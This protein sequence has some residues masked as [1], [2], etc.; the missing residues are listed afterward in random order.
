[1]R[2]QESAPW[3]LVAFGV[4]L[5]L[6]TMAAIGWFGQFW[7]TV[8]IEPSSP[9]DPFDPYSTTFYIKN[10]NLLPMQNTETACVASVYE[11][12]ELRFI[13]TPNGLSGFREAIPW[14]Q[15]GERY[16]FR[17]YQNYTPAGDP[18]EYLG[19]EVFSRQLVQA[20]TQIQVTYKIRFVPFLRF[21]QRRRFVAAAD[22]NGSF[23]WQQ[24]PLSEYHGWPNGRS[25]QYSTDVIVQNLTNKDLV[26][27]KIR[28]LK[29]FPPGKMPDD[30]SGDHSCGTWNPWERKSVLTRINAALGHYRLRYG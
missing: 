26:N 18:V 14:L 4:A 20:E 12:K 8:S 30:P 17:C 29:M 15:R 16:P 7:P 11:T 24:Q 19:S 13:E 21:Q 28:M 9:L 27:K 1:M 10:E 22:L 23:S 25:Y 6:G 3:R 2:T 5:A